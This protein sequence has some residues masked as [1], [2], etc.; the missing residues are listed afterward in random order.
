[1]KPTEKNFAI[2]MDA[3]TLYPTDRE[4]IVN[5]LEEFLVGEKL[6]STYAADADGEGRYDVCFYLHDADKDMVRV[7][8]FCSKIP[9]LWDPRIIRIQ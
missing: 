4:Q 5:E 9:K 3:T 8:E 1:M 2:S 6:G 7:N